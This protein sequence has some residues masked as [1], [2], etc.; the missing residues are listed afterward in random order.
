MKLCFIVLI[1]GVFFSTANALSCLPCGQVECQTE[2]EL[3]CGKG[4]T[5]VKDA[6]ACCYVCSK[7]R[8]EKC[9]GPFGTKGK[10]DTNKNLVCQKKD[11]ICDLSYDDDDE[12][13]P[14]DD[15]NADGTCQ[16]SLIVKIIEFYCNYWR[17]LLALLKGLRD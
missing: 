2:E 7:Q 3:D 10:C 13:P 12:N 15:V 14:I 1:I 6:C 4:V 16:N 11:P 17:K 9:G 5:L 8:G